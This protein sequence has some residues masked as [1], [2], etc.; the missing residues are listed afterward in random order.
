[1]RHFNRLVRRIVAVEWL[2]PSTLIEQ[3]NRSIAGASPEQTRL[4]KVDRLVTERTQ[5]F[6]PGTPATT[7]PSMPA[8][9]EGKSGD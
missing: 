6:Q 5:I 4:R 1:M 8:I 9:K 2:C 7:L 3:G